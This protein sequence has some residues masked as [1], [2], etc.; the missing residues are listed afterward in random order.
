MRNEKA[1]QMGQ[2]AAFRGKARCI[3]SHVHVGEPR[4]AWL[5]G[6][7]NEMAGQRLDMARREEPLLDR[8]TA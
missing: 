3:P 1:F 6:Y 2:Y 8:A 5:K 7:D 4:R